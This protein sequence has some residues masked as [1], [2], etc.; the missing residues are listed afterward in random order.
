MTIVPFRQIYDQLRPQFP[1]LEHARKQGIWNYYLGI[2][3]VLLGFVLSSVGIYVFAEDKHLSIHIIAL[4]P[5]GLL[6]LAV[7]GF[8]NIINWGASYKRQY[9][10]SIMPVLLSGIDPHLTYATHRYIPKSHFSHSNFVSHRRAQNY[11][12]ND[13]IAGTIGETAF[14]MC[15]VE[16]SYMEQNT[17]RLSFQGLFM[18][19]DFHKHF[20]GTSLVIPKKSHAGMQPV[21]NRFKNSSLSDVHL[22]HLRF[23][24]K[25]AV[26]SNDQ[27]TAR[28]I[29]SPSMMENIMRIQAKF[30]HPVYASFIEGRMYLGIDW[31]VDMFSPTL[32]DTADDRYMLQELYE[33]IR[34]CIGL[35]DD[36]N[37][38]TRIWSKQSA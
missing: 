17:E 24:N 33:D 15:E 14:W 26:Y 38:N 6:V 27:V 25:F 2:C 36:L 34:D 19:A 8:F 29:L 1:A 11:T 4:M 22:E 32:R 23:A 10:E 16:A 7:T 13:L 20:S 35:I 30:G 18:E 9:K 21:Y 37:L 28:Y 12:G 31:R 5:I 3:M